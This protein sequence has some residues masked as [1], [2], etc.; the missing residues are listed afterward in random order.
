MKNLILVHL[1]FCL[2]VLQSSL[3]PKCGL[4]HRP[5]L[6]SSGSENVPLELH[7][8]SG[9]VDA[10]ELCAKFYY[11]VMQSYPARALD[12]RLQVDWVRDPRED[13]R[14]LMSLRI[15]FEPMG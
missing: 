4:L 12:R 9:G 5:W 1:Q 11:E 7:D 2:C 6:D 8:M 3:L 10:F 14:V 15:D 13:P